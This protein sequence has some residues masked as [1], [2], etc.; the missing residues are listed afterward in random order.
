VTNPKKILH[1]R[2]FLG[3]G[4]GGVVTGAV[5]PM[6]WLPRATR[7]ATPAFG[8]VK[9][10]IL[11]NANGG[12]RS[13]CLFNADVSDQWNPP[14]ISGK[15]SG[16]SG[17]D[18]GVGGVFASDAYD[19]GIAGS[20]PS[21]PQISNDVCVL[22]TVD[23]T[24][25]EA[26]GDGTHDSAQLRIATGAPDGTIGL[27]TRVYRDH[28]LYQ[29]GGVEEN[30]PP[31]VVGQARNFGAG[32]GEWGPFRPVTVNGY[33]DFANYSD[34]ETSE[35]PKWALGLERAND[36]W[37]AAQRAVRHRAMVDGLI[38]TKRQSVTFRPIF[39]DPILDLIGQPGETMHGMSNEE[40]VA[41]MGGEQVSLDMA[42]ALR[43]VGFG[44]PAVVVGDGGWDFHSDELA[45][46]PEKGQA[47]G[48]MLAGLHFALKQL[49]HPDGGTYYDHSLVAVVS[50]F[51]RDN[52]E[53]NGFNSGSG[54]DHNGGPGSRYQGLPFFGGVVGKR[55]KFYGETNATT[56]EPKSGEPIFATN[57][58]LAMFLDVL[59]IETADHF[60]DEPLEEIF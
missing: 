46:F 4:L 19:G 39:R 30:L 1:R 31:V 17:T 33:R 34:D 37:F 55:G 56:M 26:R 38:D 32:S 53:L 18:W 27:L 22:G 44:A 2:S 51:S 58:M 7:A 24:P 48:R 45:E 41:A 43:F 12:M 13:T 60:P 20:I 49:S 35:L 42:L 11:I 28:D 15:Q 40:L 14:A 21:V 59:G 16:A 23:H 50:E 57:A 52:V 9:H 5:A 10:L 29:D 47:L 6:L 3:L 54:S 8:Q 36:D 25:G